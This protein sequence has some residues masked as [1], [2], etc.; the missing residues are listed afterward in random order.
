MS[1]AADT[2]CLVAVVGADPH[3]KLCDPATGGFTHSLVGHR[4]PVWAA[5]WSLTDQHHLLTGGCDGQVQCLC[6]MALLNHVAISIGNSSMYTCNHNVI[7]WSCPNCRKQ[8]NAVWLTQDIATVK[9]D[10]R[11][12]GQ[13]HTHYQDIVNLSVTGNAVL[14]LQLLLPSSITLASP[15]FTVA[16]AVCSCLSHVQPSSNC[17]T[18]E[19]LPIESTATL[20]ILGMQVRLWDI[21]TYNCLH[22]FDEHVTQRPKPARAQSAGSRCCSMLCTPCFMIQDCCVVFLHPLLAYRCSMLA[23]YLQL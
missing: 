13:H 19:M 18:V 8:C 2:H 14:S 20:I 16:H 1:S 17:L 15:T 22:A 6:T 3:V 10:V 5:S 7:L 9:L 4:E 11:I 12:T 21:R 23:V